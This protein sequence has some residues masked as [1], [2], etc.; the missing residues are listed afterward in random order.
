MSA[1]EALAKAEELIAGD[2]LAGL[3]S[4]AWKERLAGDFPPEKMDLFFI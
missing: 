4:A 3:K 1:E 2:I